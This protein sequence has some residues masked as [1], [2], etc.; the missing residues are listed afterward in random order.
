MIVFVE[1]VFLLEG[2]MA[3][4]LVFLYQLLH[5][6][7]QTVASLFGS[8]LELFD[9]AALLLQVLVLFATSTNTGSIASLEE[10]VASSQEL[11][12]QLV[13]QFLGHHSDG[14]PFLL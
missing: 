13:A 6:L 10:L 8:G 3:D 2:N 7:L 14:L 1:L 9:D 11:F 5:L 12:P 4:A